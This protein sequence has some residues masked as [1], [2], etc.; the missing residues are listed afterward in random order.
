MS[1][2]TSQPPPSLLLLA[3]PQAI[4]FL[5][6]LVALIY[7]LSK[8]TD[9]R[10]AKMYAAASLA[11]MLTI[12]VGLVVSNTV[13]VNLL[14]NSYVFAYVVTS[15]IAALLH[16]LAIGLLIAAAFSPTVRE[17]FSE[18]SIAGRVAAG[19]DNPYAAPI[20]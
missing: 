11:I 7:V 9:R 16:V 2:F 15:N 19:N 10:T 17:E 3:I 5:F 13:L 1:Q 4:P 6:Y 8:R 12:R 14:S 20:S 18:A